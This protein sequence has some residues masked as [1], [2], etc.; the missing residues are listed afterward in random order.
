[1]KINNRKSR[2]A[3]H[4]SCLI[5]EERRKIGELSLDRLTSPNLINS[6]E[7]LENLINEYTISVYVG[8]KQTR[9]SDDTKTRR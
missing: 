1:M 2:A 4:L 9:Q 8:E 3:R 5:E 7:K 6:I